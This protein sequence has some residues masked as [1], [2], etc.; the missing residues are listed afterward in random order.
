ME[1]KRR[2]SGLSKFQELKLRLQEAGRANPG[3]YQGQF[4]P[5]FWTV[6]GVISIIVNIF[7][8]VIVLSLVN[9][10][11]AIKNLVQNQLIGGL[12]DNFVLMDQ[13]TIQTTIPIDTE[14]RANFTIPLH[15]D[16]N[17]RLSKD[18]VITGARILNLSTGGLLIVDAPIDIV[19]PADTILPI[20]L[21]INV[22]VD[23]PIPVKM[24]VIVNIPLKDTE[25]HEPFIGL[26]KVLLPY[27]QMLHDLPDSWQEAMCGKRPSKLCR[28]LIP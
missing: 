4:R 8:I 10:M 11:F 19:L 18:T 7:L 27:N 14:V 3:L 24:D 5:A 1:N 15:I 6:A 20:Q 2:P 26:Q 9:Q 21:D 22:P 17:A 16:T 28:F 13:A 25:L 23:K 12:Y